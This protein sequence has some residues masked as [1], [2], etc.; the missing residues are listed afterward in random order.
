[1]R[2]CVRINARPSN[3]AAELDGALERG[4]LPDAIK[5]AAGVAEDRGMPLDLA[6]ALR[7]LPIS[8]RSRPTTTTPGQCGWPERWLGEAQSPTVE[9]AADIAGMLAELPLEPAGGHPEVASP[10]VGAGF[11]SSR[12][13]QEIAR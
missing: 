8:P 11:S 7:F 4:D 3:P 9:Q 12:R 6:T 5:L 1:M 13:G 10:V 2:T